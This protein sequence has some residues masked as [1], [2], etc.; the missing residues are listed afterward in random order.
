MMCLDSDMSGVLVSLTVETKDMERESDP[1]II[2]KMEADQLQ[3]V[4]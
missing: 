3:V 4:L 2:S 1:L